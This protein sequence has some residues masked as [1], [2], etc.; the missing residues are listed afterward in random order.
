MDCPLTP[1]SVAYFANICVK[2][3]WWLPLKKFF[4]LFEKKR[5]S[6]LEEPTLR[7]VSVTEVGKIRL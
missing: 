1:W 5:E 3:Y 4:P 6:V 7:G 2:I